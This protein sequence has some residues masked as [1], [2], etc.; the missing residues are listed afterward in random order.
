MDFPLN[1]SD[2]LAQRTERNRDRTFLRFG[3]EEV[4]YAEFGRKTNQAAQALLQIGIQKGDR[5]CL[6]LSNRPEFLY[7]WFGLAKIGGVLVPV[8]TAFK[9][10][11]ATYIVNH[12]EATA[13]ITE[14]A[15]SG[16]IGPLLSHC[17]SVRHAITLDPPSDDRFTAYE[18]LLKETGDGP[19]RVAISEDDLLSIIYTSGTTGRPKGAM[20]CHRTYILAGWAF[21]KRLDLNPNDR[22]MAFMPLFHI[23]A[24]IY[25][26]MGC[27]AAEAGLILL[28]RFSLSGFWRDARRYR[29]TK[30]NCPIAAA[31]LL[32]KQPPSPQ[33]R[34][35]DLEMVFMGPL[36][37]DLA[38]T[39]EDRF[40][41]I[42]ID[43]YGMTECPNI[44]QNPH[45][46]LRKVGSMGVPATFPDPS[47][48]LTRMRLVDDEDRPVP[49]GTV[50]EVTVQSPLLTLGYCKAPEQTAEAMKGGWFHTGDYAYRDEDGY[51]YFVDR[52]KDIIRRRGENISSAEVESVLLA[53]PDV[54][55]AAVIPVPSE[56]GE[57]EVKACIVLQAQ[58]NLKPESVAQWC[59]ERLARFKVPRYIEIRDSLP[60]TPTQKVEKYV[61]RQE[62]PDP[63]AGCWDREEG[64]QRNGK[65]T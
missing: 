21:T 44:C 18:D 40:G 61:L 49:V 41:I 20:H 19:P 46:G 37:E 59:E 24:Q 33:D 7:L 26:A 58:V 13:V 42:P 62:K 30:F 27:L 57:D 28:P 6:M 54:L 11:E 32:A 12:S 14:A 10:K 31:Y 2:F 55:E 5:V 9:E 50:G 48:P 39:F 51:Y 52:K 38:K 43:G 36:K 53:H 64:K 56:L 63:T 4:T 25:S 29:A 35:H 1:L 45:D 15:F 22:V 16:V 47:I 60:K 8:N 65:A 3:D 23:N 17:P 34:E